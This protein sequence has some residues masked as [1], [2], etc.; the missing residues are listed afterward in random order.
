MRRRDGINHSY[1]DY[2]LTVV[3]IHMRAATFAPIATAPAVPPRSAL[4]P[5]L[6]MISEKLKSSFF[7]GVEVI[8]L[9]GESERES[10]IIEVV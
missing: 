2:K 6:F 3:R 4:A 10:G 1:K 5:A 9:V 7:G 8:L